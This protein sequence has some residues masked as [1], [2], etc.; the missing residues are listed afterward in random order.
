M[1]RKVHDVRWADVEHLTVF[2]GNGLTGPGT[3]LHVAWRCL[4]RC[5]GEG[6]QP[7][8]RGGTNVVG[9][10]YDGALPDPYLGIE[11]MLQPD[12]GLCRRGAASVGSGRLTISTNQRGRARQ[13]D[14]LE[15]L[16]VDEKAATAGKATVSRRGRTTPKMWPSTERS[17]SRS[18]PYFSLAQFHQPRR[19][20]AQRHLARCPSG[21]K[22]GVT[23]H[24]IGSLG[25]LAFVEK[26][27][28]PPSH[29]LP[30]RASTSAASVKT[31]AFPRAASC[32]SSRPLAICR[33]VRAR[34]LFPS[35]SV[36]SGSVGRDDEPRGACGWESF[37]G[38]Q[39]ASFASFSQPS[40]KAR[41]PPRRSVG[42]WR[43]AFRCLALRS[44]P[45]L[46]C[47][48]GGA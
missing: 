47:L 26:Q 22:G 38:G 21:R 4:P 12:E 7:W 3:V 43:A 32:I 1:G 13:L 39:A 25:A 48:Q 30:S 8:V 36:L 29:S 15:A 5:P 18:R 45:W 27:H 31:T 17:A 11:P 33:R 6:R 40:G 24:T 34:L 9:E 35:R 20:R 37:S 28:R 44:R 16:A 23:E 46:W 41:H 2:N 42:S 14:E 10:S 19:E